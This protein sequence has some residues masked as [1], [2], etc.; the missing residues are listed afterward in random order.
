MGLFQGQGNKMYWS[1]HDKA[2]F[3]SDTQMIREVNRENYLNVSYIA[4][5]NNSR[6]TFPAMHAMLAC[7]TPPEERPESDL[8]FMLVVFR[9]IY[10]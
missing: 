5:N 2:S 8:L 9:F 7:W 1:D 10:I 6:S 4:N 3:P